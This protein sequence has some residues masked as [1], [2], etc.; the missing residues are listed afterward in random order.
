[1]DVIV[2]LQGEYSERKVFKG[3]RCGRILISAAKQSHK[4]AIPL[5]EPLTQVSD[6]LRRDFGQALKCIC[7]CGDDASKRPLTEALRQ[8]PGAEYVVMIGPEGDFSRSEIALAHECGWQVT[9]LGE[10]RLRIETAALT[11]V[12]AAYLF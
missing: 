1:M 12:A 2:P 11:A 10:S 6:F 7:Y 8:A 3:E 9:S 4:G 5:L